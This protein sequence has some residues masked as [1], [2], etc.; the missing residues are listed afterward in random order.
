MND[1]TLKWITQQSDITKMY[2][3]DFKNPASAISANLS[4]LEAVVEDEDALEAIT[5]SAIA[6]KSMMR[7][8]DNFLN[9]S[10]LESGE[11][12][13]LEK[14]DVTDFINASVNNVRKMYAMMEPA[15]EVNLNFT[16]VQASWPVSYAAM[17][18]ENLCLVSLQNTSSSGIV[19]LGASIHNNN[20]HITIRD[21]GIPIASEY[22]EK[23]FDRT[24]QTVA[25]T[26]KH[27]RYGRAMAMY[28]IK[29]VAQYMNGSVKALPSEKNTQTIVLILPVN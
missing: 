17:A 25:K 14:V 10:K 5:D 6:I 13:P 27:A 4:F 18:I 22:L 15:L 29:L 11:S 8:F 1:E 28:A 16:D 3:H 24:F 2:V 20:I 12:C 26:D 21:N 19:E 9:I 23:S 7:M